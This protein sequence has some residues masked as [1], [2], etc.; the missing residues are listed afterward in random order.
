MKYSEFAHIN[1]EE[2]RQFQSAV[3]LAGG[4][5]TASILMAGARGA[6]R[7]SDYRVM[8]EGISD[9]LLTTRLRELE[10]E[11]LIERRVRPTT[12]VL[13][14]YTLTSAGRELISLL[15]PL[16]QWGRARQQVGSTE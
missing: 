9:R 14:T 3:E 2:C 5:W 15:H 8:V 12:P 4:K 10:R 1:D 13:I 16:V 6:E 11:G 7:F